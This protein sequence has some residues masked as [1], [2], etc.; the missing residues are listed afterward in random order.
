[1]NAFQSVAAAVV[2]VMFM[3]SAP[4][5]ATAWPDRTVRI[6]VPL[7]PG[8]G[9]DIAARWCAERLAVRWGKPVIVENRQGGDGIPAVTGVI[10]ARDNHTFLFSFA[11]VVTI[12]PLI[13]EKLPYDPVHD[14]VPIASVADNFLAIAVSTTLNVNTVAEF[15]ML[16][17]SQPGKFTWAATPGLP[18]YA[19]AA[20][21]K[22]TGIELVR[23]SYREF[24]P[25]LADLGEGRIHVAASSI[26]ILAPP[27]QAGKARLLMV[28]NRE[29]SPLAPD[30]PTAAEAGYPELTFNGVV[31]FFGTRDMPAELIDRVAVDVAAVANDQALAN[32]LAGMGSALRVGKPA[33]FAAAIEE[34][35]AKIAATVG[36]SK[37]TP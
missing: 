12:N 34:Q 2:T 14:L 33:E 4:S 18:H 8:S 13:H 1:M 10:G 11:G 37:S 32:R 22:G 19:F 7:P 16:A 6:I 30:V 9:T 21:Q 28:V 17:R 29:R 36:A 24:A 26:N 31:G 35:R 20:I 3:S 15:V 23:A 5:S 25:A 27:V